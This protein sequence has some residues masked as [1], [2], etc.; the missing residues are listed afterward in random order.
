ML[1][2]EFVLQPTPGY[3][4]R[5]IGGLLDIYIFLGPTVEEAVEQFTE[6]RLPINPS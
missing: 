4:Y 3:V 5:T 6:V 1:Q 2:T